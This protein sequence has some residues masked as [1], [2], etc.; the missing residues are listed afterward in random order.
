MKKLLRLLVL[1]SMLVGLVVISLPIS[2]LGKD[3]TVA[4]VPKSIG[5]P[6]WTSCEVG[7][8]KAGKDL[9]IKIIFTAPTEEDVAK[10]IAVIEDLIARKVDAII[11]SPVD[12]KAIGP[13]IDKGQSRGVAMFTWDIDAPDTKRIFC[14]S[15]LPPEDQGRDFARALSKAINYRGK[16]ALLTGALGS[17]M[18]NRR[19][20]GAREILKKYPNIEIVGLEASADDFALGVSQM[21]NLMQAHPNLKGVIGVSSQN[22]PA[23]ATAVEAAGK[24]GK[25]LIYGMGLPKQ[26]AAFIKRGTI[27]G[28][29]LWDTRKMTYAAVKIAYDYVTSGIIPDKEE[30]DFGWAGVFKIDLKNGVAMVPSLIFDKDNVDLFDF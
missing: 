16:V 20:D 21:E 18:L 13:V 17:D 19:L 15:V 10:Q 5:H 24:S 6:Y 9:G 11:I 22:P 30:V 28:L 26:N 23:A 1:C 25:V 4:L 2:V 7:A 12:S 3:M 8:N 29:Q 14:T 27:Q